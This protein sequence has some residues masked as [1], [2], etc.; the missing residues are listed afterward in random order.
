MNARLDKYESLNYLRKE[1]MHWLHDVLNV[2]GYFRQTHIM[3]K[4][5]VSRV[6]AA[7]IVADFTELQP[8]LEYNR[9][10]HVYF[11]PENN[12]SIDP[13]VLQEF[14]IEEDYED[15]VV[16]I[17]S[18]PTGED[19]PASGNTVVPAVPVPAESRPTTDSSGLIEVSAAG[20]ADTT[21]TVQVVDME[22]PR[23]SAQPTLTTPTMATDDLDALLA[24][25]GMPTTDGLTAVDEFKA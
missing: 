17:D 20:E 2:Y 16:P 6:T 18:T 7:N 23:V 14:G 3:E 21:P 19:V 11:L 9:A 24:E 8:T 13:R 4:F 10:L 25:G 22:Q 15:V 12:K 1:Q 5:G